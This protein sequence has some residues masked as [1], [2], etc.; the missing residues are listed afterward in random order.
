M[1]QE[2]A[3]QGNVF[4]Q[5]LELLCAVGG[6]PTVRQPETILGPVRCNQ[7]FVA[8]GIH[9]PRFRRP[10]TFPLERCPAQPGG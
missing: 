10:V 8:T 2:E 1:I 7:P 9:D 4:P 3:P 5:V 6:I